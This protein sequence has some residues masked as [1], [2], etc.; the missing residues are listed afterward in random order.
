MD[1]IHDQIENKSNFSLLKWKLS[2]Q[3][4]HIEV[5]VNLYV[6]PPDRKS[7]TTDIRGDE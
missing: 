1:T 6:L 2:N 3:L 7:N 5:R 4:L